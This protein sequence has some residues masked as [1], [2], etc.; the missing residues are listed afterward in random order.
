MTAKTLKLSYWAA[1]ALFAMLLLM[2]GLGGVMQADA[3]KEAL[4]HLGYPTYLLSIAGTAK[5]LAAVAV[6]QTRFPTIKEWAF[7]GFAITCFGAFFSRAA[8]G[9]GGALL[10]LP[11]VFL[12]IMFVPYY[13]WKKMYPVRPA[14][15]D[16][17]NST[18]EASGTGA[19]PA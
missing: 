14:T 7:A 12:A 17:R 3:G 18:R 19:L 10:I 15:Q 16:G 1:T 11:A 2:D 9:D 5:I 13:L 8:V 6:L 4:Q